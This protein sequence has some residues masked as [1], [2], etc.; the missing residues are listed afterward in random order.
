[1]IREV[2]KGRGVLFLFP[3]VTVLILLAAGCSSAPVDVAISPQFAAIGTGQSVQ[4]T[5]IATNGSG[6][7]WSASAGT[8]N[9]N[10]VYV[11]P[12]G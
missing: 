4:F 11:A 5:S 8:I 7:T 10:G 2:G 3:F 1:M 6:V 9:S 12:S